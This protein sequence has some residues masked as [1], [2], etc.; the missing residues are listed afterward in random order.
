MKSIILVYVSIVFSFFCLQFDYLVTKCM[1][2]VYG[3]IFYTLEANILI[4]ETR[5][6][7]VLLTPSFIVLSMFIV[8]L[9]IWKYIFKKDRTNIIIDLIF[10]SEFIFIG[11]VHLSGGL[12]WFIHGW[13]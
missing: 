13:F 8:Y 5:N 4:V 1:Q 10:A 3:E 11:I 6:I 12:S 9:V 2:K 7:N